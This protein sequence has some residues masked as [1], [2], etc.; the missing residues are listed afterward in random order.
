M[1]RNLVKIYRF[2]AFVFVVSIISLGTPWK[3]AVYAGS[4][5]RKTESVPQED[6]TLDPAEIKA[7]LDE[8]R[9]EYTVRS[10]SVNFYLPTRTELTALFLND[11]DPYQVSRRNDFASGEDTF[12]EL[13]PNVA[14]AN[15]GR[16][17]RHSCHPRGNAFLKLGG[18]TFT[19]IVD[20]GI[21]FFDHR[22]EYFRVLDP[23]P[24]TY[25]VTEGPD[26]ELSND[27]SL[28]GNELG[29]AFYTVSVTYDMDYCFAWYCVPQQTDVDEECEFESN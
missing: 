14:L 12:S 5:E 7:W 3:T 13:L 28:S 23:T 8:N 19:R 24:R 15:G 20:G 25:T 10:E 9:I 4:H 29:Y 16:W 17:L 21:Y 11:E 27:Q 2:I 26:G 18:Q 1:R 22:R 6:E